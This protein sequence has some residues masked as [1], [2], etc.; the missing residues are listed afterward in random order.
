MT[1]I[2]NKLIVQMLTQILQN[3]YNSLPNSYIQQ[4]YNFIVLMFILKGM[5]NVKKYGK[6]RGIFWLGY[7]QE[8]KYIFNVYDNVIR[9]IVT[10]LSCSIT[11][12]INQNRNCYIIIYFLFLTYNF[13]CKRNVRIV[14]NNFFK[15]EKY[16][17]YYLLFYSTKTVDFLLERHIF[18]ATNILLSFCQPSRDQAASCEID[19][20]K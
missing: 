1:G 13:N 9:F 15:N 3:I 20:D 8:R 19:F 16:V 6:N 10:Y 11:R 7:C 12:L 2:V 18:S 5:S 4:K 17:L 14:Q